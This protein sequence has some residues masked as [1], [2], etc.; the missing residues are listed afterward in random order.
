MEKT[1]V[2]LIEDNAAYRQYVQESL[3]PDYDVH[4]WATGELF[5]SDPAAD[6]M[7]ILLVDLEL[8]H[9]CG[10]ELIRHVRARG[11][12]TPCLVVSSLGAESKIVEAI[13]AGAMGYVLKSDDASLRDAVATILAGGAI[14]SSTIM[15]RLVQSFQKR[16]AGW[17][18]LLSDRE[19]QVVDLLM[20]G[21]SRADVAR[22]LG[23]SEQT[24]KTQIASIYRKLQ[25]NNRV[26]LIRKVGP[27]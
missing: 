2:G 21:R 13:E 14:A 6:S 18:A 15:V 27:V 1:Q 24:V 10:I 23:T 25:V 20:E 5:L 19:A 9:M 4:A 16:R 26:E 12:E 22:V 7:K 11:K 17:R 8:P 3:Q